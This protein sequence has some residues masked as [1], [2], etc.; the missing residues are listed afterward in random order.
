MKQTR[1]CSAAAGA[2]L[3]LLGLAGSAAAT[4]VVSH[5]ALTD[6]GGGIMASAEAQ[7]TS[8]GASLDVV[9]TN[10]SPLHGSP[11]NYSNPFITELEFIMPSGYTLDQSSSYVASLPTTYISNGPGLVATLLG[12]QSLAYTFVGAGAPGMNRCFMST[13][14]G[15]QSNDNTIASM[16]V[17]DA[18]YV[19][20]ENHAVGFLQPSPA[21]DSG[22]VFDS[23]LFHLEYVGAAPDASFF[24]DADVA[25]LV[26]KFVGG[27]DYSYKHVGNGEIVP[28]PTPLS[29]L[30]L[31]LVL[32]LGL[33]KRLN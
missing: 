21:A 12:V 10:T 22:A 33:R 11:G 26:V 23:A 18:D 3:G 7:I 13:G 5:F 14:A 25:S 6:I 9:L 17:L 15:N 28:E 31:G 32:L 20:L 30:G 16:N 27:G 1:V 2:L 19:P 24:A 4:T 8:S 29:L